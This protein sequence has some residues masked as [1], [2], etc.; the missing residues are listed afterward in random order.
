MSIVASATHRA[1]AEF[2]RGTGPLFAAFTGMMFGLSAIPFYTLGSFA[3]PVTAATGWSMSQFQ[4]AFT[5]LGIGVLAGPFYGLACD[6][7]GARRV[8]LVSIVLFS[9]ALAAIGA[10]GSLGLFAFYA[11]W[12]VMALVGQGTGPIVWTHVVTGWFS[13]HRGLALGI[14]LAGSGVFAAFGPWLAVQLIGELGWQGAYMALGALAFAITFPICYVLLRDPP[15]R[16]PDA[17]GRDGGSGLSL[18]KA[19]AGY[20]F[21]LIAVCFFAL[22]FGVAGLISNLVP[23]LGEIGVAREEAAALAG[24]VGIAVLGGRIFVGLALDRF[25]APGVAAIVLALPALS[26]LALAGILPLGSALAALL[27]GFAAGAEFD[28]VAFLASRFF[29]LREYGRIYSF[30]YVALFLG[31]AIA[32][33]VFGGVYD[34][35]GNYDSI[36]LLFAVIF[37]L[38]ATALLAL[39]KPPRQFS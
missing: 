9:L 11:A 4:G 12:L 3:G 32:P 10:A 35:T 14:V 29:G 6:R 1:P 39:R 37:V 33:P 5:F 19:M 13:S 16:N 34:E 2:R 36:L 20:R 31:A 21:W 26:C 25:W 15:A 27:I 17:Q 18:R 30:L 23:M 38:A 22:S 7:M 28:I 24:L 8:G